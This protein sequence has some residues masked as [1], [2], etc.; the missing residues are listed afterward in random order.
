[1][2][3]VMRR[4]R[5]KSGFVWGSVLLLA[6]GVLVGC[7]GGGT[8]SY[9]GEVSGVVFDVDGYVVRGARVYFDGASSTAYSTTAG[10]YSLRNVPPKDTIIRAEVYKS[11]VRYYGQNLASVVENERAKNVNLTLVPDSQLA[12]FRG[13]VRDSLGARLKG[14]R[15]FLRPAQPGT[16]LSSSYGITDSNGNVN[17]G[18]LMAGISYTVQVNGLGY[19]SSFDAVTLSVGNNAVRNYNLPD[20]VITNVPAPNLNGVT[21]YT[22]PPAVRSDG[23]L[24]LALESIKQRLQPQRANLRT[25]TTVRGNP[26]EVDLFWDEI[27]NTALLGYGVYRGRSGSALRNVAFLR[28]PQAEFF[29]DTDDSV[30]EDVTYSYAM[31]SLDTLYDGSEGESGL[32]T[33]FTVTPLGDLLLGNVTASTQPTIRWNALAGAQSYGVYLFSQYP[34]I[35]VPELSLESGITGTSY[36]Y[37]GEPLTRGR[38]YYYVVYGERP[39]LQEGGGEFY[40]YSYSLSQVGQ[41]IVP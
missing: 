22:S 30:I 9:P 39:V 3:S 37:S 33:P 5:V 15:V 18:G 38:T 6:G 29:A 35:G 28:D 13:S 25:R 31:T 14:V 21:A 41:F 2:G 8:T 10:T 34:G 16:V 36:T 12:T 24:G 1:M 27:S 23:R 26:I 32:S 7:G 4:S 19:N 17:V 11:G 20:G 40:T